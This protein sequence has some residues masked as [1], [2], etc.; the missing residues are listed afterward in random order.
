MNVV[1]TYIGLGDFFVFF[2]GKKN[3]SRFE[4][5]RFDL[6]FDFSSIRFNTII[7]KVSIRKCSRN[8]KSFEAIF[9]CEMQNLKVFFIEKVRFFFSFLAFIT[10]FR[11]SFS[12]A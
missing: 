9:F 7:K 5:S 1:S 11:L 2:S 12:Y 8:S 3:Y 6:W 10:L 4:F